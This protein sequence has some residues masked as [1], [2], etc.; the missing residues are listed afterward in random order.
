MWRT[1]GW[2]AALAR[3]ARCVRQLCPHPP[4]PA[5][6]VLAYTPGDR[7]SPAPQANNRTAVGVSRAVAV[8]LWCWYVLIIRCAA[9]EA[10]VVGG[11]LSVRASLSVLAVSQDTGS[12]T[13]LTGNTGP[14]KEPVL[15]P[16]N[17]AGPFFFLGLTL[18]RLAAT[19]KHVGLVSWVVAADS[20]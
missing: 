18:T 9:L 1:S 16:S 14:T 17:P 8:A 7:T 12:H 4:A 10:R 13:K 15:P 6:T 5:A 19:R 20:Q 3:T 11:L 2:S